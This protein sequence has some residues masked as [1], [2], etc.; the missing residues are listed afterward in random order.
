M[1]RDVD[2]MVPDMDRLTCLGRSQRAFSTAC[3]VRQLH[4]PLFQPDARATLVNIERV[5]RRVLLRIS[6]G[7]H[8][9]IVKS[10]Q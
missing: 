3:I 1:S 2:D 5:C 4:G 8:L 6:S 10:V 7:D 9:G